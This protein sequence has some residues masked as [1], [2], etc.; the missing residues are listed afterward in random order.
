MELGDANG[1]MVAAIG[2]SPAGTGSVA[3][4]NAGAVVGLGYPPDHVYG[5]LQIFSG[6]KR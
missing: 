1:Y 6:G 2:T 3:V 5:T 4:Y